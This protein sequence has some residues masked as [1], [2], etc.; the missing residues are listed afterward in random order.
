MSFNHSHLFAKAKDVL[1]VNT[2]QPM[3]VEI[4]HGNNVS[5]KYRSRLPLQHTGELDARFGA[6]YATEPAAGTERPA[7]ALTSK[8]EL[9]LAKDS[10][11]RLKVLLNNARAT[12]KATK[13]NP[14][15][16]EERLPAGGDARNRSEITGEPGR[17]AW[18]D[19]CAVAR[20]AGHSAR[21]CRSWRHR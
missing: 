1:V 12:L 17:V 14:P 11:D 9:Q 15:P 18:Q 10:N 4:V 6:E 3:W 7:A 19:L 2:D 20:G 5:N 13:K 16:S 21:A 8:H